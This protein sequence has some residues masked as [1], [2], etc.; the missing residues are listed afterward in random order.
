MSLSP[1]QRTY[2]RGLGHKLKPVVT[3]GSA[4]FTP[5]VAAEMDSA[6]EHHELL[7]IKLPGADKDSKKN[8]IEQ[9][10]KEMVAESV[11]SIGNIALLYRRKRKGSKLK[12]PE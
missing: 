4:G 7:K 3:I 11:Q 9:V 12:L 1:K 8:L 10:C 6:L 5:A 2:L